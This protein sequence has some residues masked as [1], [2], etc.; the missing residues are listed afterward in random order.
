MADALL[1]Y[2]L[3]IDDLSKIRLLEPEVAN[4]SN[5]LKEECQSFISRE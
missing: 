4:Q 2:G 5:K 1:K 3:F